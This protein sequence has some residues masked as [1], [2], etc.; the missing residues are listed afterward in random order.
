MVNSPTSVSVLL[1]FLLVF[2]PSNYSTAAF[3]VGKD[4]TLNNG[5]L[6]STQ[7][8]MA[9]IRVVSYNVLSPN[10]ATTASYPTLNPEHLDPSKRLEAVLSKIEIEISSAK[11]RGV[12]VC[13][14]EVSYDWA[15]SL[16]SFFANRGYHMVTGLY[17]R[18][19]N[20]YMGVA[21][22]W[23]TS[24]FETLDVDISRLSDTRDGGWPRE[25]PE[26]VEILKQNKAA[27]SKEKPCFP[28][29][30][31]LFPKKKPQKEE[32]PPL[33]PWEYSERRFN[34]LLTA[35]LKQKETNARFCVGTYHMPCAFYAPQVMTI[36][37]EMAAYRVQHLAQ[38]N[39]PDAE[40]EQATKTSANSMRLPY[41]VAGDWNIK[42]PDAAY[43]LL[44][45]GTLSAED[46]AYPDPATSKLDASRT[47]MTWEP[48]IKGMRSTY[49][50]IHDGK[51]PDYTNYAAPRSLEEDDNC[52]IDTLDYIFVSPEWKV[53]ATTE[54]PNRA[55]TKGPFPNLDADVR[56]PSDHILISADLEI[57]TK[58]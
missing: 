45:T 56:E 49:A 28:L 17:G 18:P 30:S 25:L 41:I 46:P 57:D 40:T 58:N 34:V 23:P 43:Q 19:F 22:A 32:W 2:S 8:A 10:L 39:I 21:M 53:L 52:F 5:M 7:K 36:H 37:S 44:T 31:W 24:S 50:A 48:R 1:L 15:G 16:H 12:I 27:G 51:E 54:P 38:R 9:S 42:P 6:R 29:F 55:Q 14:Q 35:T 20:G 11:S 47:L 13:L 3:S 4:G 26:D 33:D